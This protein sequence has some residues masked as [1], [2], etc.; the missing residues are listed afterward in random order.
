M[1]YLN[2]DLFNLKE[3]PLLYENNIGT[4]APCCYSVPSML[5]SLYYIKHILQELKNNEE[6]KNEYMG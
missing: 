4:E 5:H 1:S 3:D 6:V 2:E